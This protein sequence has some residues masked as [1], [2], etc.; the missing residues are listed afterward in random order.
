M[1]TVSAVGGST[2]V[3]QVELLKVERKEEL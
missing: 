1:M 2:L 3:F